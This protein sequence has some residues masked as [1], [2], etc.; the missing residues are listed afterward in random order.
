MSYDVF[1]YG[2]TLLSSLN[3]LSEKYP[4]PDSYAEIKES[5]TVPGGETINA[6][7]VLSSYGCKT[8]IDGPFFGIKTK[9]ALIE[10]CKK[11]NIDYSDMHYDPTFDGVQDYVLI[12]KHS[13]TV[14]GKFQKYFSDG[15][16]R[17]GVPQKKSVQSA[18]IVSIDPFFQNESVLAA[19]F[20]VEL[21]KRYVT[22]DC[23][24]NEFLHQHSEVNVISNEYIRNNYPNED[25]EQLLHKYTESTNGLVI[26]TFGSRQILFA[27]KGSIVGK[28]IPYKV[29]VVST[30]GAGDTF[31]AGVLYALLNDYGDESLVKF[32]AATAGVVCTKFPMAFTPPLLDE[33]KILMK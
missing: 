32:A 4:E 24:Y 27:R 13:R 31:R 14:F 19:E 30:L 6:A 5:Y 33:V 11:F 29:N 12:D 18:K 7:I 23:P 8:K 1:L 26:F 22:I 16:K 15:T 28:V 17:W 20:C 3:L 10:Y 9:D 25:V 2:Q 21:N